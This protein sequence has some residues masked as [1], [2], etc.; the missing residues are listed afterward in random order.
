M[1]TAQ[2]GRL[3]RRRVIS[4]FNTGGFSCFSA[5]EKGNGQGVNPGLFIW[6]LK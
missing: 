5:R 6:T 3:K 1:V 4:P 2:A